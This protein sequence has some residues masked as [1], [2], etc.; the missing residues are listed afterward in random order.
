[1]SASHTPA[2]PIPPFR[3]PY[4]PDDA[5]IAA[6]L[7]AGA[8]LPK[9]AEAR[10]DARA[11]RLIEAIR[12][13]GGGLGGIEDFLREYSLSTKEGL[14]LMVLAEALLRVPD[15]ETADKLIEDKIGATDWSKR[16]TKS[17]ALLVSASSWALGLTSRVI[18]PGET[19]E[20]VIGALAKRMGLPAVRTATRQAMRMMGAHF[21]LGQTIEEALKRA[22]TAQGRLFRYSFDMLGEGAR[23]QGDAERYLASY[24][25]AIEAIGKGAGTQ[26]LPHRPGISVKLSALHPRYEATSAARVMEELVPRV[27]K[28]AQAAKRHDL[29]F[30]IDAEEADRLELSLDVVGAVAADPSLSGWMGYGLAIQSYQKRAE[31]VIDWIVALAD[32]LDRVFMVR[33]VKGAYWDTEIKRA[34]ERGLPDYPLFTRKA[35]TDLNYVA[36]ARKMLAARP[37]LYPQFATHNALT[38]ATLIEIAGGAEGYEFQRLHGMGE[39][40]YKM[41]LQ[42]LPGAACRTY[43]PV[44]GHR[45]LL[46][47]LVRRLLENGANS[48]FVSVAADPAVPIS[49]LLARPQAIIATPAA[50]RHP[51]V[52]LP[53]A[54]YP[55]RRNSRGVELGHAASRE[56]LLASVKAA[57]PAGLRAS[58]L[59]DGKPGG[60]AQRL[61]FSPID[62]GEIGAVTELAPSHAGDAMNAAQKGFRRWDRAGHA[63][64]AAALD[65]TADLL[66]ARAPHFLALLQA[67]GGKT[68]DDAISEVREAVDFCRYYAARARAMGA[69]ETMPGPTGEDNQLRYRG[70]GVFV[71]VSPWNFPLA[72]FLGQVVAALVA[73]NAVVAKPAEQTP[74]IAFEAVKLLHEA[75]VPASALHLALGDG[76]VG[77]ALTAHPLTAGVAFTGSTEVAQKINRALA[78]REGA[79]V[80]LIAETGGVNAMIVDATALPEQVADDV[81]I[82]AFR[83]AGQRCSAL[84]LLAVQE[85][86]ADK[87]I[88]MI[89]GAAAELKIGDPRDVSVQIGPVIDREAKDKL[90]AHV[91]AMRGVAKARFAG[92]LPNAARLGTF[93]APHIFELGSPAELEQETFGPVLHVARYKASELPRVLDQIEDTG[94]GLTLGVHSRIDE[95]IEQIV[96][97]LPVGNCYV[98]RNIIGAVVGTQPFGGCGLSGTG[99]KAGGP[100][101]LKRFSLEQVV[102]INTAA[103]GGNASLIAMG[104]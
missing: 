32:K 50:A 1:M 16:E 29:C 37:R 13:R 3:A 11:T 77:A 28:L 34:Q 9:D 72:I 15:A 35:M 39:D 22:N 75:G 71:C 6:R 27:L 33:L 19:P 74:L 103:A 76:A 12:A 95:T 10:V 57:A 55:E 69:G 66:E 82:S 70:R 30:T 80:P 61:A 54:L 8:N 100:N 52:P 59:I 91:A 60:G 4:A 14:A 51:K 58:S 62:G 73:G 90:D 49:S 99:P 68:I 65:K 85:E 102:S 45:D 89:A 56:A 25:D 86:G 67:E 53:D 97:R 63:T 38:M 41:L 98:N 88:E 87:M 96:E 7:L 20:G 47:Y 81:V 64:R 93:V 23:T 101:Y 17:E 5:E 2:L 21:V 92:K 46:A 36:C 78:A 42:D 84:R 18:Q 43:A 79:I 31:D 44:G 48:S 40:A 24:A 104:E 83:S 94:F 26:K